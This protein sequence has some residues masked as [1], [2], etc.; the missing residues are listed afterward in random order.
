M[1][2]TLEAY[3]GKIWVKCPQCFENALIKCKEGR[4]SGFLKNRLALLNWSGPTLNCNR[5]GFHLIKEAN[6][7]RVHHKWYGPW[8]GHVEASCKRCGN[9]IS[10]R[11]KPTSRS[12]STVDL[13]CDTCSLPGTFQLDWKEGTFDGL[14]PYFG[15]EFFYTKTI[16]GNLL[17]VLNLDHCNKLISYIAADQRATHEREKWSMITN[18]PKWMIL[19]K[20]REAVM[21]ALLNIKAELNGNSGPHRA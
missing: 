17:W 8:T 7:W 19:S 6:D 16:K 13:I 1:E 11:S 12:S 9:R 21:K 20:N 15:L 2:P 5:C 10:H 4:S 3:F 14:D 18:L